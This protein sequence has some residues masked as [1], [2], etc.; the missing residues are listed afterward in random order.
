MEKK[1]RLTNLQ[2]DDVVPEDGGEWTMV[3]EEHMKQFPADRLDES[4]Q[5]H[6]L[7][8]VKGC[9]EEAEAYL[10]LKKAPRTS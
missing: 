10:T 6:A 5:A 2:F 4:V 7:C 9:E 1:E 8:G 3:C